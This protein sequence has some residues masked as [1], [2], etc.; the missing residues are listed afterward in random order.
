MLVMTKDFKGYFHKNLLEN[1]MK[2][3]VL[4]NLMKFGVST[5]SKIMKRQANQLLTTLLFLEL[6]LQFWGTVAIE[7]NILRLVFKF[8]LMF[9]WSIQ[10]CVRFL[11]KKL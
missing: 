8:Q 10:N 2:F 11:V 6:L 4:E 1:F 9:P 5:F 7:K 3:G